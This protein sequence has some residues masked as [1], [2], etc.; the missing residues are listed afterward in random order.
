MTRCASNL[1]WIGLGV[2]W[3]NSGERACS[4]KE[5]ARE[6]RDVALERKGSVRGVQNERVAE[7][8]GMLKFPTNL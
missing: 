3:E 8:W 7:E 2:A 1:D 6:Q 4:D 5:T